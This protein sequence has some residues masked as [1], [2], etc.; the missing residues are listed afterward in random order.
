MPIEPL[1]GRSDVPLF[2][3]LS[4]SPNDISS[5]YPLVLANDL[6]PGHTGALEFETDGS[7][8]V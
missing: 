1:G 5:P 7:V 4:E 8:T 3:A 6:L 2:P